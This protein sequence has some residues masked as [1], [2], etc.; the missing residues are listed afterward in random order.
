MLL[1]PGH[2][3]A[4]LS[5]ILQLACCHQQIQQVS[6]HT[7]STSPVRNNQVYIIGSS[8][9]GTEAVSTA[10]QTLGYKQIR[11]G[12]LPTSNDDQA[13]NQ[14]T[15]RVIYEVLGAEKHLTMLPGA[16]FI[17]PVEYDNILQIE[18]QNGEGFGDEQGSP[19][20][21]QNYTCLVHDYFVQSQQEANLLEFHITKNS[22]RVGDDWPKLC[23][24]LGLGYSIVERY[25][26]RKFP[27]GHGEA[28]ML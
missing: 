6:S 25:R 21:Y 2:V 18:D 3:F 4:L 7:I 17:L 20:P 11:P 27:D 26:L 28:G 12:Y 15:F 8:R 5:A 19:S 14:G 10:L 1:L 16:K 24:F 22:D 13:S 23:Q 9:T